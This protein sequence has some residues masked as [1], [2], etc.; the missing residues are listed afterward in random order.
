MRKFLF[1][2]FYMFFGCTKDA[3]QVPET[4]SGNPIEKEPI[5]PV[6]MV[7]FTLNV[8][9]NYIPEGTEEWIIIHDENGNLVDHKRVTN[10]NSINFENLSTR[11]PQT[12][13]VTRFRHLLFSSGTSRF[14]LDTYPDISYGAVWNYKYNNEP[15]K[16]EL[17]PTVPGS[18][19]INVN[20]IP[21]TYNF[22]LSALQVYDAYGGYID[23]SY[24]NRLQILEIPLR[25][26]SN[27]ILSIIDGHNELKYTLLEN[28]KNEDSWTLDYN[29]FLDF[30]QY[31]AIDL[32]N[33]N[34][35]YNYIINGLEEDVEYPGNYGFEYQSNVS[36]FNSPPYR[37]ELK[38]G[39]LDSFAKYKTWFGITMEDENYSYRYYKQGERPIGIKI[40]EKPNFNIIGETV[41]DFYF[42]SLS[43]YQFKASYW[44]VVE[45]TGDIAPEYG[46]KNPDATAWTIYA[47]RGTNPKI[48]E[49]PEELTIK[50]PNLNVE[51]LEYQKTTLYL[52]SDSYTNFITRNFITNKAQHVTE[53][54]EETLT[55]FK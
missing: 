48:A 35:K 31:V 16:R 38:L 8:S 29:Q 10:G 37:T 3:P 53:F 43:E 54:E 6:N 32:P 30:D 33:Q 47:D 25:E 24:T 4:D 15:I 51:N 22:N 46:G 14:F 26:T 17:N 21:P 19:S 2:S 39:Y 34:I 36:H 11:T 27:Y 5:E 13:S 44:R 40:P 20:N 12:Y 52:I 23:L 9:E 28:V 50:F 45:E 41:Y 1:L 42:T 49:F 7:Y 55:L 18:F